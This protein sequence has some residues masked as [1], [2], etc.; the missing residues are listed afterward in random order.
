MDWTG[1]TE[2]VIEGC[3]RFIDRFFRLWHFHEVTF[4]DEV[5]GSDQEVLE[6]M[7][8]TVDRVTKDFNRWSYN[9]AVAA[10]MELVNAISK[11]ARSEHGIECSTLIKALDTTAL[12]LAP[13]TPHVTA[14]LWE[15]RYPDGPGS[16]RNAMADCRPEVLG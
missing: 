4:H 5:D 12:L 15:E 13:M 3:A 16:P 6:V 9:T 14:E 11:Q 1:Q 7:H 2:E 8:R 10:V